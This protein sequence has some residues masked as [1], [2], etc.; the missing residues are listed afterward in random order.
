ME[1]L[2]D[3]QDSSTDEL[4]MPSSFLLQEIKRKDAEIRKKDDDIL[5][6]D[7]QLWRKDIQLQHQ[8]TEIE[9]LKADVAKLQMRDETNGPTLPKGVLLSRQV[10]MLFDYIGSCS[11]ILCVS[12][13]GQ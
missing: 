10:N 2:V 5:N 3:K 1:G 13:L 6:R 4:D 11:N 9:T 8:T 7:S 12:F